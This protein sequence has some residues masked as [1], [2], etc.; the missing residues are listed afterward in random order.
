MANKIT[1]FHSSISG[2]A[3]HTDFEGAN[4]KYSIAEHGALKIEHW[5]T[6]TGMGET[7]FAP[8]HW[9]SVSCSQEL[10]PAG[11]EA[12]EEQIKD[13]VD[14]FIGRIAKG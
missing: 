12:A 8:G 14:R 4:V 7:L 6:A 5:V 1:V 13:R 9:H 11:G 3:D 10:D 2:T